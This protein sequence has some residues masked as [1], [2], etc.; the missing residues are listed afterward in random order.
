M[1]W[2]RVHPPRVG[3]LCTFRS[4]NFLVD[5][6]RTGRNF[7]WWAFRTNSDGTVRVIGPWNQLHPDAVLTDA[8]IQDGLDQLGRLIAASR[9]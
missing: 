3:S 6:L 7:E 9:D 5:C 2:E 4:G 1:A 8:L